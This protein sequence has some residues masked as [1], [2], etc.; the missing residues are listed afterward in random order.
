MKTASPPGSTGDRNLDLKPT[1]I[2]EEGGR[3]TSARKNIATRI[4]TDTASIATLITGINKGEIKVPQF[5]R[6][7]VWKDDQS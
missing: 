2:N 6:K 5:Q 1:S 3:K 7:F 4:A